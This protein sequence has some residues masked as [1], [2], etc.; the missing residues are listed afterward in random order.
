M[1]ILTIVDYYVPGYRAGGPLR[2][3]ENMV[4]N[5]GEQFE[6]LII[7]RD[8]DFGVDTPYQ[9]VAINQWNT[10]G[11]AQVYY[12]DPKMYSWQ[13]LKQ[14]INTQQHDVLYLNSFFSFSST[15]LPLLLR[16]FNSIPNAPVVIAP[17][18]EFSEGA[19]KIKSTKKKL[20]V[21]LAKI[22]GVYR[23]LT[24]QAS[25]EHE[26]TDIR[27]VMSSVA[28]NIATAP[29]LL[30]TKSIKDDDAPVVVEE[31]QRPLRAI[32]LSRISRK[33]N[34]D[35][36]LRLLAG[37]HRPLALSVYGPNE[38]AQYWNECLELMNQVS[39]SVEVHY[40]GEVTP[41]QVPVVFS[42]NDVFLFPTHGENFGHVIFES[43][44]AGTCVV[45]T[46][47]DAMA[48]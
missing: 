23:G 15:I 46:E 31:T 10:V 19:F 17:R 25:S 24:W 22:M 39:D 40:C 33:K 11:K 48:T 18:G 26:L 5:L 14:I 36:L 38:D 32:F 13:G 2:T 27:R 47:S 4:D 30:P 7:T 1:R 12:A 28:N 42:E 44:S 9:D 3:I 45:L 21:F 6:F 41:D 35:Y 37:I 8:R 20:F 34:L 29:D 43:L 16:R